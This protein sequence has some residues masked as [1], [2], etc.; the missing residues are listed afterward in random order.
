MVLSS[1]LDSFAA[2][3]MLVF[4]LLSKLLPGVF[5]SDIFVALT[6]MIIKAN[7]YLSILP[8]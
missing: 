8:V 6:C 7:E 1:F 4:V 2:L 5:E 3:G